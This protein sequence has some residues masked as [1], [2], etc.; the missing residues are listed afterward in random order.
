MKS[1][2]DVKDEFKKIEQALSDAH[3]S[4]ADHVTKA[5]TL[6]DYQERLH[7]PLTSSTC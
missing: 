1:R 7:K 6:A 2:M 3:E 4:D 5:Q